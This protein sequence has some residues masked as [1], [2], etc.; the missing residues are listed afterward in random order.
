[1]NFT[2]PLSLRLVVHEAPLRIEGLNALADSKIRDGMYH[3]MAVSRLQPATPP[4]R[5]GL[6]QYTRFVVHVVGPL[7][8]KVLHLHDR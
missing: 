3:V 2:L 6:M 1:M 4:T 5:I 8:L 7:V